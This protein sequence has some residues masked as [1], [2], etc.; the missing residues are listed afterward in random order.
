M[1]VKKFFVIYQNSKKT[2]NSK[3]HKLTI[4]VFVLRLNDKNR[5]KI[6]CATRILNYDKKFNYSA[7][8]NLG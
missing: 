2:I 3:E 5:T 7:A 1:T 8:L 4:A 6:L